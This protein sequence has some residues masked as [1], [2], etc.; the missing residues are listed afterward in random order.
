MKVHMANVT[1]AGGRVRKANL[2]IQIRPVEVDLAAVGMNYITRLLDAIFEHTKGRWVRDLGNCI[3]SGAGDIF[4]S[5]AYHKSREVVFMLFC[6]RTEVHD[7]KAAIR[8]TLHRDHLQAGHDCGLGGSFS[9][10]K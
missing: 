2:S 7:V 3:R 5:D 9:T 4:K 1:T 10:G 8:Q 6:L